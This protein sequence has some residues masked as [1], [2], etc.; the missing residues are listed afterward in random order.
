MDIPKNSPAIWG[1]LR[2]QKDHERILQSPDVLSTYSCVP[3]RQG[4]DVRIS[5]NI[6]CAG[7][8]WM[9]GRDRMC[10]ITFLLDRNAG[11]A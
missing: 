1:D 8:V 11:T 7:E 6:I 3:R 10:V 4:S 5:S 9:T 2:F